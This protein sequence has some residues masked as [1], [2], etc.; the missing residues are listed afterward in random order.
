MVVVPKADGSPRRTVDLQHLNR[1][2]VRQTHHV[3]S[4]FHLADR[5]P[6]DTIKTVTDAWNGYHSVPI[7]PD[8]RHLT[9][10]ITPW[11]R[12]RYKVAPQG[13]LA[14]G[15]AYNQR[16]DAIIADF[17]DKVKCV[18]DTLMWSPTI[19]AAFF[20]LCK[21]CD[22][23]YRN[24]VTLTPK[25]LQF[26]LPTVDFAGLTVTPTN[27]RPSSKFVNSILDFP[28]PT[29]ISGARAWFGLV[30]QGSYAFAMAKQMKP[31]RHLLKPSNKFIWNEELEALF[32]KSKEV[33]IAEMKEGV[34]LFDIARPTC[35]S[36]DWSTDGI[37]F[38]LKQKYCECTAMTPACCHDGW[39]L[40]LV[41]SRFT[42]PAESRY[43]PIEGEALA[44][45]YA[46]HQTRYYILGCETLVVATDHK[47][48]VRI[49]DG[50]PLTEIT[51]RRLLN[52][53]EKTLP[54]SFTIIHVPGRHNKGPDA[55][56]RYPSHC[57]E[58]QQL[59]CDPADCE[60]T[61]TPVDV[62]DPAD[63]VG[64]ASAAC[65]TLHSV[66]DVVTWD[67]VREATASDRDLQ[68]LTSALLDGFP[69]GVRDLP[70]EVHPFHRY[71]DSL[72]CV[73]GVLLLGERIVVPQSLRQHVLNALHSAHQGVNIMALGFRL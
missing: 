23:L 4:P 19:Q 73:D 26:A 15:D 17:P 60:T 53:K 72:S 14:S 54:Y 70:P 13:F 24:G 52:L 22:L 18:D 30:N 42:T 59:P 7:H 68:L 49:L 45:V 31:F 47:P 58:R 71:R 32:I 46:L 11:G 62:D 29:D 21:W 20:Q 63:D 40:C 2:A 66:T 48:L 35:L 69:D 51:N 34:R 67:M 64:I 65:A 9:T 50:R 27:V 36:T 1:H 3:Q 55:A 57:G 28:T 10:F 39:K 44:V 33:M 61:Y 41:G 16:F 5:V 12:Y 6:Q 25:K 37:G 56:S 43:S 38:L 8:D